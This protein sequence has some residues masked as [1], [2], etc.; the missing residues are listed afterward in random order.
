MIPKSNFAIQ[1]DFAVFEQPSFTFKLN[2][3]DENFRGFVNNLDAVKQAVY[4]IL[5][6]ERYEYLIYDWDYGVEFSDLIGCEKNYAAAEIER[7]ITEALIQDERIKA[8]ENFEFEFGKKTITVYFLVKTN[9][10]DF[11]EQ[12]QVKI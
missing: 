11:E 6:T 9:F 2:Y 5:N 1:N 4:L 12:R 10:G 3:Q 8:V 7:R